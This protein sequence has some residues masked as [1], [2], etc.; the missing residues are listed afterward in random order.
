[1]RGESSTRDA[2]LERQR[3][4][5]SASF[6]LQEAKEKYRSDSEPIRIRLGELQD[7]NGE[8][9]ALARQINSAARMGTTLDNPEEAERQLAKYDKETEEIQEKLDNLQEPIRRAS[10][11]LDEEL[12]KTRAESRQ[13]GKQALEDLEKRWEKHL[14]EV[15]DYESSRDRLEKDSLGHKPSMWSKR[16]LEEVSRLNN[17]IAEDLQSPSEEEIMSMS[18]EE[19]EALTPSAAREEAIRR[20]AESMDAEEFMELLSRVDWKYYFS[21]DPAA[22]ARGKR[23]Y[24][25]AKALAAT[26]PQKQKMF[27]DYEKYARQN[28][29]GNK[30][31]RP[32]VSN[33]V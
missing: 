11:R 23:S 20:E 14:K 29:S 10:S 33:Y 1:M 24:S 31:S 17:S 30:I 13:L 32:E 26:D 16:A 6:A 21:D 15:R 5:E 28:V 7:Q 22:E 25:R 4:L 18:E 27:E 19:V 2:L 12:S 3:A 8:R 9:V